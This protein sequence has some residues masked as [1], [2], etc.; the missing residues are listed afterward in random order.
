MWE[1]KQEYREERRDNNESD[2]DKSNSDRGCNLNT[3]DDLDDDND[4][5]YEGIVTQDMGLTDTL[6]DAWRLVILTLYQLE[7]LQELNDKLLANNE[8][9][10]MNSWVETMLELDKTLILGKF[11]IS[12]FEYSL[13]YF[14]VVLGI[15]GEN[16]WLRRVVAYLY[17]LARVVY[18]MRVLFA[19]IILP[20]TQTQREEQNED[21]IWRE[22]FLK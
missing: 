17:M 19:K 10:N 16:R 21:P 14:C 1:S 15:D 3:P 4:S 22:G 11:I 9:V 2:D 8:E 20:S 5:K 18:C 12:E 7:L 13:V 6:K